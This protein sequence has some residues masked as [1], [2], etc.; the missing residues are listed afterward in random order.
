[1]GAG[2][3]L[4]LYQ[5]IDIIFGVRRQEDENISWIGG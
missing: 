2:A 1:M 5:Y 3:L 4:R